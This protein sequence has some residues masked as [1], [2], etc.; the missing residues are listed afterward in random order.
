MPGATITIDRLKLFEGDILI[1]PAKK[2]DVFC[3]RTIQAV[4]FNEKKEQLN[5]FTVLKTSDTV[6]DVKPGDKVL[7]RYGEHT[8]PMDVEGKWVAISDYTKVAGVME[9]E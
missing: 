8:P 2:N 4:E 1:E 6:T 5:W 9:Y 7:I 3:D